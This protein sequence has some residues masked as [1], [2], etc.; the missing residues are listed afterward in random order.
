MID[1]LLPFTGLDRAEMFD[2]INGFGELTHVELDVVAWQTSAFLETLQEMYES[3]NETSKDKD[4][5]RNAR[6]CI[7]RIRRWRKEV[8][9]MH[10][11]TTAVKNVH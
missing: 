10:N 9:N 8:D 2:K 11:T 1:P 7:V 5:R 3:L 4:V 6:R